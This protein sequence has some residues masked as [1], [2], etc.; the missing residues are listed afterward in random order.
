MESTRIAR[1]RRIVHVL[2]SL[3]PTDSDRKLA[4][5]LAHLPRDEFESSVV[6]LAAVSGLMRQEFT[7]VGIQADSLATGRRLAL[8]EAASLCRHLRKQKPDLIHIWDTLAKPVTAISARL[9]AKTSRLL[10]EHFPAGIDVD[11]PKAA[12]SNRPQFLA[13]LGLPPGARL[14]G[15]IEELGHASRLIEVL[16]AIDQL[17]VRAR[18]CVPDRRRRRAR[19][20]V[21]R[22][23]RSALPN[24]RAR[25]IPGL[26]TPAR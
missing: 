12:D 16:W 8:L 10:T 2:A 3:D 6:A 17:R 25:A 1:P 7:S 13:N 14:I 22:T 21:V 20:P 11:Q 23:I 4:L 15:A 26:A 24:S 5:L 18:R 19:A 9:T